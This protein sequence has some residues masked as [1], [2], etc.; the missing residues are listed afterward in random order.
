MVLCVSDAQR[1]EKTNTWHSRQILLSDTLLAGNSSSVLQNKII[2]GVQEEKIARCEFRRQ[3]K[4]CI[5]QASQMNYTLPRQ[6]RH[7]QR[8]E[9]FGHHVAVSHLEECGDRL[10]DK[11]QNATSQNNGPRRRQRRMFLTGSKWA[12]LWFS[13]RRGS[14]TFLPLSALHARTLQSLLGYVLTF[15]RAYLIC[16]RRRWQ[17]WNE[18]PPRT[19]RHPDF[20]K[21]HI[22]ITSYADH[23]PLADSYTFIFQQRR[24]EEVEEAP[25]NARSRVKSVFSSRSLLKVF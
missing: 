17:S 5:C 3:T 19:S 23:Q 25:R 8:S 13:R 21:M 2:G 14:C 9:R 7:R 1:W 6:P 24:A 15:G 11:A 16:T 18:R 4:S 10:A 22:C 12:T 20:C